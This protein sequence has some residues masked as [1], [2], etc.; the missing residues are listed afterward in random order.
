[1][2][3]SLT[4]LHGKLLGLDGEGRLNCPGGFTTSPIA[5]DGDMAAGTGVTTGTGTIYRSGV[6]RVG[7]VITTQI[8]LDLTG[9]TSADSDDDVIGV[10][11]T[12]L[13][14]HLGQITTARNGTIFAGTVTCLELPA[15]LTDV[16]FWASDVSTLVYE[17]P[18]TN[19]AAETELID[20][21][22]AWAA[23]DIDDMTALP[24]ANH[25][26]YAVN[27]ASDTPAAFTAGKWLLTFYGYVA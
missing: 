25:Y 19:G 23:M 12:A 2:A 10:E 9:C 16:N 21:G 20:K 3:R 11:D 22:G 14:C 6:I 1:M 26:L 8:L 17:N 24:T 5:S 13:V 4:S 7:D 15:S 27:G 18:I